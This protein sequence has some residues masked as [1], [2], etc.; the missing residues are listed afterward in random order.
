LTKRVPGFPQEL[1]DVIHK[2]L[3]KKPEDRFQSASEMVQALTEC[4]RKLAG[5]STVQRDLADL[6][7]KLFPG[8]SFD[9]EGKA[10][11]AISSL[12]EMTHSGADMGRNGSGPVVRPSAMQEGDLAV[13]TALSGRY[14]APVIWPSS[15]HADPLADEA[16]DEVRQEQ[17]RIGYYQPDGGFTPH[18]NTGPGSSGYF[19]QA[20]LAPESPKTTTWVLAGVLVIGFVGLA[21]AVVLLGRNDAPD[22][23]AAHRANEAPAEPSTPKLGVVSGPAPSPKPVAEKAAPRDPEPSPTS[24]VDQED[25][26]RAA[27][28]R[29]PPPKT[30]AANPAE[31]ARTEPAQ[32]EKVAAPKPAPKKTF[33]FE[34][35]ASGVLSCARELE[36]R[37][38]SAVATN[39]KMGVGQAGTNTEA[40]RRL[41]NKCMSALNS[42]SSE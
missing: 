9:V 19:P 4:S 6:I 2:A 42:A 37:G 29:T 24:T 22:A 18:I 39:L 20:T 16:L 5:S 33:N 27:R 32:P 35:D 28:P 11:E 40:L 17:T 31:P 25:G 38:Q 15:S 8:G 26:S 34:P 1:A 12:G 36:G 7:A 14:A 23:V 3:R 30:K 41:L 10:R 21:G 13:P